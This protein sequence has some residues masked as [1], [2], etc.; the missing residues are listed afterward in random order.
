M[1]R[2]R[3]IVFEGGE[4]SGK[5]TQ[6]SMLAEHLGA[7]GTHEP[8]GTELGA[9]LREVLLAPVA[10]DVG[11]DPDPDPDATHG[12][13]AADRVA[14]RV[15]LDDRAEALLMAADR[16]QHVAEVIEPALVAGR[17]V[18]CDRYIGSTIAYQGYG[19]GLDIDIVRAV[20][21]WAAGGLWPD[22]VV[23]LV[24]P[25][26]VAASRT[27]VATDRIEAAGGDF[28]GRVARGFAEQAEDEPDTWVVVDGS[29]SIDEVHQRVLDAIED[30]LGEL[31]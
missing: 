24:V 3:F 25:A 16:A 1:T 2:G 18:V 27:G 29:G 19:R 4:G 14:D 8:G 31:A 28:H 9:R 21:G 5:S 20:S 23:L 13:R 11:A 6:A 17:H 22:M 12:A 7:V 30:V 10:V 26:D 15:A